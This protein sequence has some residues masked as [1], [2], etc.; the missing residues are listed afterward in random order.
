MRYTKGALKGNKYMLIVYCG[1]YGVVD[2]EHHYILNSDYQFLYPIDTILKGLSKLA[3]I[4]GLF[5]FIRQP[6]EI[7]PL[8]AFT[9]VEEE[10]NNDE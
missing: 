1:G 4:V 5:D 8:D 3:A 2:K 9:E 7:F 6:I 10:K